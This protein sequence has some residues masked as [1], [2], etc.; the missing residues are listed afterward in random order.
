MRLALALLLISVGCGSVTVESA[1]DSGAGGNIKER[2]GSG[3]AS[4][5]GAGGSFGTGGNVGTGGS[6]PA[7]Y[8]TC[9]SLS[10]VPHSTLQCTKVTVTNVTVTL[11]KDGRN[12]WLCDIPARLSTY[13]DCSLRGMPNDLCVISCD[14][15]TY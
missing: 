10:W 15:C 4:D 1:G 11:Y 3:G 2:P 9:D 12:C 13:P 6:G 8:V 7:S 5:V 14:E